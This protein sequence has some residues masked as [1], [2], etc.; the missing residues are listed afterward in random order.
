MLRNRRFGPQNN[1]ATLTSEIE[2]KLDALAGSRKD[3]EMTWSSP[4][5]R[6][7]QESF[8]SDTITLSHH[9]SGCTRTTSV[10]LLHHTHLVGLDTLGGR[11]HTWYAPNI[12][13][14]LWNLLHWRRRQHTWTLSASPL[15]PLLSKMDSVNQDPGWDRCWKTL[16]KIRNF[17]LH[18]AETRPVSLTVWQVYYSSLRVNLLLFAFLWAFSAISMGDRVAVDCF[19]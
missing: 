19:A 10:F 2:L 5:S 12:F 7:Q 14:T 1:N 17:R 4:D 11:A 13:Q 16:A 8:N 6:V 9:H 18:L 15:T 3:T